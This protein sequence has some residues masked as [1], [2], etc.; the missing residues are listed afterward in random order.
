MPGMKISIHWTA[1]GK[2]LIVSKTST[3]EPG[4]GETVLLDPDTGK[5]EKFDLPACNWVLD[6][7]RDG[8]TL[9]V[10]AYDKKTKKSHLATFT[11]GDKDFV[12]WGNQ[13]DPVSASFA[14]DDHGSK[15]NDMKTNPRK[16]AFI[17]GSISCFPIAC[18]GIFGRAANRPG[19]VGPP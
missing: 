3:H 2:K 7:S 18:A 19:V 11:L 6:S 5:T 4:D 8:K 15:T 17:A 16:R 13:G 12:D 1:D 10:Q 14:T 9:L